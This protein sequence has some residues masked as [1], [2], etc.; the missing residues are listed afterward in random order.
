MNY[1]D[2]ME[3]IKDKNVLH[4]VENEKN[5]DIIYVIIICFLIIF[6]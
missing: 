1:D 5:K 2:G 4:E 3:V 6:L